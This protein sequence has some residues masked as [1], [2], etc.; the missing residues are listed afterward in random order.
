MDQC[1]QV[2]SPDVHGYYVTR[3]LLPVTVTPLPV[4]P[5]YVA[6]GTENKFETGHEF[7]DTRV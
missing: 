4:I 2:L 7:G 1:V 5:W 3:Y 6:V